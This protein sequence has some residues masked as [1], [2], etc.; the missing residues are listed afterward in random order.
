[1]SEYNQGEE[2]APL[3]DVNSS[4]ASQ[5]TAFAGLTSEQDSTI[6][7]PTIN[8]SVI[9]EPHPVEVTFSTNNEGQLLQMESK[10]GFRF[11]NQQDYEN[12]G[13]WVGEAIYE[14]MTQEP[15]NLQK[16]YL[17]EEGLN[18]VKAESLSFVFASPDLKQAT[19]LVVLIHGTGVVRAGQWSRKLIIN[20]SLEVGSQLPYIRKC[21]LRGWSVLVMNTNDNFYYYVPSGCSSQLQSSSCSLDEEPIKE[22]AKKTSEQLGQTKEG[23]EAESSKVPVDVAE[24]DLGNHSPAKIPVSTEDSEENNQE[25]QT[26]S[27]PSP[28]PAE[29]VVKKRKRKL[30]SGSAEEH[31]LYVWEN[32]VQPLSYHNHELKIAIVAHS[33]G[34][35]VTMEIL[36][37]LANSILH[38]D[39]NHQ[40]TTSALDCLTS[41]KCICLTD[42]IFDEPILSWLKPTAPKTRNW[43]TSSLPVDTK[44]PRRGNITFSAGTDEHERTSAAAKDSVFKFIEECFEDQD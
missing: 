9:V 37:H 3:L 8:T 28:P 17:K 18:D 44:L 12:L 20:E 19:H 34:G 22:G 21:Q 2:S 33:Y 16:M 11:T 14:K 7:A 15:Y 1:M 26:P 36:S 40:D 41:I 23:Q 5:K 27:K 38:I 39:D 42:A 25:T 43:I 32:Y 30:N 29:I 4:T 13:E 24:E 10:Q 6:Q 31:G 35:R